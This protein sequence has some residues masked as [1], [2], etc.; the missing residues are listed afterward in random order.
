MMMGTMR[1]VTMMM[2]M[3]M[4]MLHI[5]NI[6]KHNKRRTELLK[7]FITSVS[8][9]EKTFS[10]LGLHIG[11]IKEHSYRRIKM[12]RKSAFLLLVILL[13]DINHPKLESRR[14]SPWSVKWLECQIQLLPGR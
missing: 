3:M 7:R 2:M 14:S 5:G 13:Q 6:K 8:G 4:M 10:L 12:L 1:R 11:N 9:T